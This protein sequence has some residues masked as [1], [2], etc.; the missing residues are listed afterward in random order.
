MRVEWKEDWVQALLIMWEQGGIGRVFGG[1]VLWAMLV[2]VG[3]GLE[4]WSGRS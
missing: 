3:R 2:G 4:P 1:A